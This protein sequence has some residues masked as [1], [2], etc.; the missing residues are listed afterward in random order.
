MAFKVI[1]IYENI[2][3]NL[4]KH[5]PDKTLNSILIYYTYDLKPTVKENNP[6]TFLTKINKK[7]ILKL[8]ITKIITHT[9][10]HIKTCLN[11]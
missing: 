8:Q 1:D 7:F 3:N 2:N 5:S 4:P 9:I 10:M 11:L 6:K